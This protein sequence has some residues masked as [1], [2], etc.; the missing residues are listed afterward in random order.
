ITKIRSIFRK[1]RR[2]EKLKKIFHSDCETVNLP[3]NLNPILDCPTRWNSTHDMIGVALK[4]KQGIITLCNSVL[5]LDHFNICEEEWT[6]LEKIHKFLINF[7]NL[8]T[9][10]GGDKYVTLPFV[11]ISFNL[12][13]DRI[14]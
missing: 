13:L 6:V 3:T 7:K 2:S 12:L 5:E 1:I 4:L 9:R 11:I 14:E 8:T 10:L